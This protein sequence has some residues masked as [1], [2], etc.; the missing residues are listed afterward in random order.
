MMILDIETESCY[1]NRIRSLEITQA[2]FMGGDLQ[3]FPKWVSE[4]LVYTENTG[5]NG[6]TGRVAVE[7]TVNTEGCLEDIKVIRGASP[8][9]DAEALRVV[10][11]SPR[12]EPARD[13]WD[14]PIR[15][16][17]SFPVIFK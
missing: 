10:S 6:I 7:F 5:E 2:K 16:A 17:Y 3:D 14:E 4:R 9:L 12:W 13:H 11:M 15:K 1:R 8:E